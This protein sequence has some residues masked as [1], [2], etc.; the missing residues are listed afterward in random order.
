MSLCEL[1]EC[2]NIGPRPGWLGLPGLTGCSPAPAGP[3]IV[4]GGFVLA[5]AYGI[6][7]VSAPS[8][9]PRRRQR[10]APDLEAGHR[11]C[12]RKTLETASHATVGASAES[13]VAEELK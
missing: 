4:G 7:H 5:V 9:A 12:P 2:A 10:R 13:T 11:Q 8:A 6:G 3:P 1:E